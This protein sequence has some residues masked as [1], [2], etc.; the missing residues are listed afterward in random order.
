VIRRSVALPPN[1]GKHR[2]AETGNL[3]AAG[4]QRLRSPLLILEQA[5]CPWTYQAIASGFGFRGPLA[6][7]LRLLASIAHD[8]GC[9]TPNS[10]L[11]G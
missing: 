8:Q 3:S 7:A 11:C 4:P 5:L 9:T 10:P 6:E 1:Q 2:R